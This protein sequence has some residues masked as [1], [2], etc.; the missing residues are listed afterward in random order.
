MNAVPGKS[1]R[2]SSL[3]EGTPE[4]AVE[5]R[6]GSGASTAVHAVT[7]TGKRLFGTSKNEPR[8]KLE[9]QE[10]GFLSGTAV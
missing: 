4:P 5:G 2:T 7:V 6:R 10:A 8:R 3:G 9:D 1:G